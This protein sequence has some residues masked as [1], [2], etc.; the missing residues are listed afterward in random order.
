MLLALLVAG[1]AGASGQD[2]D[3]D[4]SSW[5]LVEINGVPPPAE[6]NATI[7]FEDGQVSGNSG[8]NSYGGDYTTGPDTEIEF[9]MLMTTMMACIEPEGLMALE[10][11]F[12]QAL[13]EAVGFWMEGDVL[14]MNNESGG[15]V[16]IFER[17]SAE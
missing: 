15:V 9:G 3:L 1:C 13:G 6:S 14:E 5:K 17:V 8:C 12:M 4:G 7:R 2:V 16:L 10:S 11:A